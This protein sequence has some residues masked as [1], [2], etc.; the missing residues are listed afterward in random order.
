MGGN[1]IQGHQRATTVIARL[2]PWHGVCRGA[3]WQQRSS[4]GKSRAL[5]IPPGFGHEARHAG[6]V[7]PAYTP[8]MLVANCASV[9]TRLPWLPK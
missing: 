3:V 1:S 4:N 9:T 2:R 5:A 7:T 8:S 6:H